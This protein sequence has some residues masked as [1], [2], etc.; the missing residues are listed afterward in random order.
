MMKEVFYA[1]GLCFSCTRCSDCC[2][3]DPG[4]VFL[5]EQDTAA[6]VG[7]LGMSYNDFVET[8]CR[9]VA[10]AWG[11]ERLALKE[12]ANYDCVFWKQG[13]LVYEQRPRQCRAFPF[14]QAVVVS[15]KAWKTVAAYCPGMNKGALHS[16]EEIASWLAQEDAETVVCRHSAEKSS[17]AALLKTP[18]AGEL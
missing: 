3:H 18:Q 16:S 2:R 15:A 14:W 11:F 17:V 5:S 9:W 10:S 6:L 13:C 8:Y 4:Y 7:A 12:L 1:D